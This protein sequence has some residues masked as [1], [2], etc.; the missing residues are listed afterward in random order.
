MKTPHCLNLAL[1]C[2]LLAVAFP[3]LAEGGT[4]IPDVPTM[5][6]SAIRPGMRGEAHTV[7]KGQAV[8][9]F[10]VT[11]VSIIPKKG[12]PRNLILIRAEGP[13]IE[14]TGG[15]AAGMSGS[16]VFIEGKLIG[17]I[18]YGWNF[19]D[20]RLGLV[21]P[22][23]D[24]S[25]IFDWKDS[26]PA[27]YTPPLPLPSVV[28]PDLVSPDIVSG[29]SV[30]GDT[31][32]GDFISDDTLP[33]EVVFDDLSPEDAV[34]GDSLPDIGLNESHDRLTSNPIPLVNLIADGMSPRAI[35]DLSRELQQRVLPMGGAGGGNLPPTEK[36]G[37]MK[38]GEA[39]GVLLAWGDVSI[40]ATGTLTAVS[41]DGRF[42]AFAHPFINSGAVAY[43]LTRAWVHDIVP[44]I[45]S[46]FK[47]GTPLSI[48]GT[49]N[50]DRPQA[51]GG[52]L[53]VYPPSFD[54]TLNF[55]DVD[56]RRK[57]TKR[58]HVA[59]APFLLSKLGPDALAGLLD[60]LWGQIG[61]G[62]AKLS[63]T[64]NGP[65]LSGGWTRN[66]LFF[67]DKDLTKD[68]LKELKEL[69]ESVTLNPFTEIAPLGFRLDVEMTAKPR[70]LLIEDV[71]L[72]KKKFRPG[73][74][75]KGVII[76][77]PFRKEPFSRPFELT[78]PPD[79][80]GRSTLLV[81][82]GGI[83]EPEQTS[84]LEGKT[85]IRDLPSLLKEISA[86]ETNNQIVVE[87]LAAGGPQIPSRKSLSLKEDGTEEPEDET[88]LLSA[89]KEKKI[90]E[91]TMKVYNSNYYVDGLQRRE[92]SI[93]GSRE[94]K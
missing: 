10:P 1:L 41:R 61:A 42:L 87:I 37:R 79:A 17:A 45:E 2:C 28:S 84:L 5:K 35:S 86:R 63:L 91:G 85:A 58:F 53:N 67:S 88:E 62:T 49:V 26:Q 78:V 24:M 6:V 90:K 65:N 30:S 15:I 51:I 66:N 47:L 33:G 81:R 39:V 9:R 19:S 94:E 8:E 43:P 55:D 21:T 13:R 46:P 32:S 25:S 3:W 7:F 89:I 18:G 48:I 60:D 56:N 73:E 36:V 54:F 71:K 11:I 23:E 64:V 44:S 74:K 77:R 27:F 83:N 82:G 14:K 34:S 92:I 50:Q 20:H 76:L 29:D 59:L 4:F 12:I 68:M 72:E 22:L 52:R 31:V 80:S 57:E 40:G 70:I 75:V 93:T 69:V 38:P 16:P